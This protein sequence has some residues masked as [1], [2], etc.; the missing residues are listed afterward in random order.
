MS[1][2]TISEAFR[3]TRGLRPSKQADAQCTVEGGG[4]AATRC[5]CTVFRAG[6]YGQPIA[7]T[8]G[9]TESADSCNDPAEGKAI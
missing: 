8:N 3:H 1:W 4:V 7:R 6:Q 9:Q 2:A 5:E